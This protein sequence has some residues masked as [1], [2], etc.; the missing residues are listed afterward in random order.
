VKNG[1]P[2]DAL[3]KLAGMQFEQLDENARKELD[4]VGQFMLGLMSDAG[5]RILLMALVSVYGAYI[6]QA[7]SN[8]DVPQNA[9]GNAGVKS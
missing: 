1:I 8:A 7:K 6:E 4:K 2:A 9:G 5:F 3:K